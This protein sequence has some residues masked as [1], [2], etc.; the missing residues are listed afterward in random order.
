MN[1][2]RSSSVS[3]M[4]RGGKGP[5]GMSSRGRSGNSATRVLGSAVGNRAWSGFPTI[6]SS[7]GSHSLQ[8]HTRES[9]RSSDAHHRVSSQ[10]KSGTSTSSPRAFARS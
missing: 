5:W 6:T 4:I 9:A 2:S 1:A 10:K 8:L 7:S 3:S